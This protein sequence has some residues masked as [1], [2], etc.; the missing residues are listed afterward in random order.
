MKETMETLKAF[1][2]SNDYGEGELALDG[3]TRIVDRK[4]F[5]DSH[6]RALL[7][8]SSR[9]VKAAYYHRLVKFKKLVENDKRDS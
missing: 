6:Y 3:C 9:G 1:V 5:V 2:D 7:S 4:K 8:N